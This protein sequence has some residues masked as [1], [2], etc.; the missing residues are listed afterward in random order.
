MVELEKIGKNSAD[1]DLGKFSAI[2]LLNPLVINHW[3]YSW[4]LFKH[5]YAT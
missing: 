3:S 4:T 5:N 1:E 2:I